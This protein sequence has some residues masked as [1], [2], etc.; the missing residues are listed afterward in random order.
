MARSV[1]PCGSGLPQSQPDEPTWTFADAPAGTAASAQAASVAATGPRNSLLMGWK[2]LVRRC[3]CRSNAARAEK[4][5]GR[6]TSSL[7]RRPPTSLCGSPMPL[8]IAPTTDAD[9]ACLL[10]PAADATTEGLVVL[11]AAA[12]IRA[13]NLAARLIVG[14]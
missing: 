4:L 8:H 13:S 3:M 5:R 12:T 2:L 11:D 10:G 1:L 6:G 7:R 14:T 9:W